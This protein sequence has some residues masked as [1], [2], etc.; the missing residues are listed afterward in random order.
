MR[1]AAFIALLALGG[2][3][4]DLSRTGAD[5][6]H[7][8][9]MPGESL[10]RDQPVDQS[11]ADRPIHPVLDQA[12]AED[13]PK[14]EGLKPPDGKPK[15]D[16]PKA[17]LPKGVDLAKAD[18]KKPDQTTPKKDLLKP[19]Q[20]KPIPDLPKADLL[21]P[22]LVS[23]PCAYGASP[24][25]TGNPSVV[26]CQLPNPYGWCS[27]ANHCGSS[28]HVCNVDEYQT[29]L[30]GLPLGSDLEDAWLQGLVRSGGPVVQLNTSPC[31]GCGGGSVASAVVGLIGC[32][33]G[34]AV[35]QTT[36][37]FVGVK[38]ATTCNRVGGTSVQGYWLPAD[39]I[40]P[41]SRILCCR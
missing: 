8:D 26:L 29:F 10:R 37:P 18:L 19:D 3:S 20:L 12:R 5:G 38:T 4:F 36:Y 13:K 34:G 16:A 24:Y 21:K 33:G 15:A 40:A 39:C 31:P 23:A 14:L 1:R 25:L 9:R 7:G 28:W 17:D 30:G 35:V 27:A 6:P 2:C 11:L 22:D 41:L 32:S